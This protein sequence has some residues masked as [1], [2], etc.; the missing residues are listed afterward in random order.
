MIPILAFGFGPSDVLLIL[1]VI[2][3]FFGPKKLPELSRSLGKSIGEF[4]KGKEEGMTPD[5]KKEEEQKAVDKP[6]DKTEK[7]AAK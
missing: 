2:L 5:P 6:I 7:P 1:L 4:K 3:L